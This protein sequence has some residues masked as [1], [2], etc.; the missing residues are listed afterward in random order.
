MKRN[1]LYLEMDVEIHRKLEEKTRNMSRALQFDSTLKTLDLSG[2]FNVVTKSIC[3][4]SES[5]SNFTL[6]NFSPEDMKYWNNVGSKKISELL[7]S[8]T[9]LTALFLGQNMLGIDDAKSIFESLSANSTLKTLSL[10][11]NILGN[12]FE[13]S[14]SIYD[15][16]SFNNSITTLDIQGN[17]LHDDS[18]ISIFKAL[19]SNCSITSLD[20]SRND[21]T[22]DSVNS[23]SEFISS[24][25]SLTLLNIRSNR[26]EI[27]K[28][29]INSLKSNST[30]KNLILSSNVIG[31]Y[32]FNEMRAI[33]EVFGEYLKSNS[34]LTSLDISENYTGFGDISKSMFQALKYNH[35]L[36]TLLIRR[37]K[38]TID[39]VKILSE[40]LQ[41]NSTLTVLDLGDNKIGNDGVNYIL[42]SLHSNHTLTD[43]SIDWTFYENTASICEFLKSNLSLKR[44]SIGINGIDNKAGKSIFESL[45]SNSTLLTLNLSG[46]NIND[47]GVKLI[48]EIK[49][50][51]LSTLELSYNMITNEAATSIEKLIKLNSTLTKLS[52]GCKNP[53]APITMPTYLK[54]LLK[55][56]EIAMK[57]SLWP[58]SIHQFPGQIQNILQVLLIIFDQ[59]RIPKDL[60]THILKHLLNLWANNS[61]FLLINDK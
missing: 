43:L 23:I 32:L 45:Q 12:G 24:S 49:L 55:S 41:S 10:A 39:H 9:T 35:T 7:K 42:D 29:L 51:S 1:D 2:Q 11:D 18:A 47:E 46:N 21:L 14:K 25:C 60:S 44:F 50:N 3:E 31:G 26:I 17:S 53:H 20:I 36:S 58:K 16:L 15:P 30:L 61:I 54:E 6:I 22:S 8:N 19:K 59:M 52:Y 27:S 56:N 28:S 13:S 33:S 4:P 5:K 48:S 38:L 57:I 37:N 34:T 40:S